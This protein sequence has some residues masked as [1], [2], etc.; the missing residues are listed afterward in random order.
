MKIGQR[1]REVREQNS[2]K[3]AA[4]AKIIGIS[5]GSLSDIENGKTNPRASTLQNLVS[6]MHVDPLWLL[7]GEGRETIENRLALKSP[8]ARQIGQIADELSVDAQK[9]VLKYVQKEKLLHDLK[10]QN[11]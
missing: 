7:T 8:L 1:I 5:Q 9:D 11:A 6:S 3:T 4:F 10:E 2:L